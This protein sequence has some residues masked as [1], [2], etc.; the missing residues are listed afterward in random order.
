MADEKMELW[1]QLTELRK[2]HGG[3]GVRG[4]IANCD[5]VGAGSSPVAHPNQD[6]EEGLEEARRQSRPDD[7]T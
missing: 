3:R 5:F 6:Q 2:Q 7:T 1:A 4:S